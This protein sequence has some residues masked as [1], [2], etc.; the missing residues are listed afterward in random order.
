MKRFFKVWLAALA[1]IAALA[2][3]M[4]GI[5]WVVIHTNATL[6]QFLICWTVVGSLAIALTFCWPFKGGAK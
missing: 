5:W 2:A 6:T 3:A 1:V 4:Q